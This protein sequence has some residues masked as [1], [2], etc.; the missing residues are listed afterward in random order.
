MLKPY[1][2]NDYNQI[3]EK[4][5]G[6]LTLWEQTV[7]WN[8]HVYYLPFTLGFHPHFS[9]CAKYKGSG[10]NGW[11]RSLQTVSSL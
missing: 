2:I 6:F 4:N 10:M 7:P 8:V 9:G 11:T 5:R 1:V 3:A